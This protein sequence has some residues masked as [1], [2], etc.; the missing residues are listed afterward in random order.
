L[1]FVG[2]LEGIQL[3]NFFLG[4]A[5]GSNDGLR[6]LTDGFLVGR[7]VGLADVLIVGVFLVGKKVGM[8][9]AVERIEGRLI[10]WIVGALVGV[11]EV[12]I[13]EHACDELQLNWLATVILSMNMFARKRHLSIGLVVIWNF[14]AAAPSTFTTAYVQGKV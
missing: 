5:E 9:E 8:G 4:T 14:M 13:L 3:G 6:L 1:P 2:I 12:G 7:G 10:V 11:R